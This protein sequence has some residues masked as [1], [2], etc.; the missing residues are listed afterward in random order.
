MDLFDQ[1]REKMMDTISPLALRMRPKTLDEIEGQDHLLGKGKL[2]RRLIE[3]DQLQSI[4]LFGPPGT[5]KTTLASIIAVTTK[6]YFEQ[7]N[8]SGSGVSDIRRITADAKDRLGMHHRRTVLFL[9]E[10]HRFNKSQ[11]DAL[12]PHVENGT[13]IL[14]GATTETPT[15]EINPALVSRSRIFKLEPLDDQSV[16][17]I[18]QKALNNKGRGLGHKDIQ[19][20]EKALHHIVQVSNGDAR[21]ALNTLEMA[22]IL[23]EPDES[24]RCTI[25]LKTIEESV[26]H[27]AIQYDKGGNEHY[28]IISAFIKSLRG[29]DPDAAI[30]WL[31][32]MIYAGEDPR[33]IAR[34]MIVHAAED[35]GMADPTSLTIATAA[36]HAVDYVGLPEARIPLAQAAIHIA[37]APKSNSVVTAIDKA[38]DDVK[39]LKSGKVP[40]HL[41]DSSYKGAKNFGFGENYLYPHNY[42]GGYVDQQYLPDGLKTASYYKPTAHGY[43]KEIKKEQEEKKKK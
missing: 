27:R 21:I 18:I 9:D 24:G 25:D 43:E 19:L 11:Q 8:A 15:F 3:A 7:L 40:N 6:A 26:Q 2:L 29:S 13:I 1:Q 35:V 38:L 22:V 36:A 28:D 20:E 12:L 5:G 34:R 10:I 31:A 32:K 37:T 41:K 30:Y 39:T 14:I 17:T 4:I 23:Q 33:F 16:K 42:P